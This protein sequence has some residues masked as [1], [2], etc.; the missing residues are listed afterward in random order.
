MFV[1]IESGQSFGEGQGVSEAP[2]EIH[3]ESPVSLKRVLTF[4]V[5]FLLIQVV[6][7]LG[8]HYFGKFGFLGVSVLGGL[9]AV[10]V[11]PRLPRT[12]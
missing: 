12:W 11:R 2:A 7:T 6:S 8:E 9:G 5:L 3:L 10:R 1:G 4:A